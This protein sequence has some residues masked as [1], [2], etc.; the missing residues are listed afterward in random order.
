MSP[1]SHR[2]TGWQRTKKSRG[3]PGQVWRLVQKISALV[4]IP[5]E[6]AEK[7]QVKRAPGHKAFYRGLLGWAAATSC[8]A[9]DRSVWPGQQQS[10]RQTASL[11]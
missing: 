11:C 4:G 1:R 2:T 10:A 5:S 7:L 3:G 9:Q 8:A 6:N